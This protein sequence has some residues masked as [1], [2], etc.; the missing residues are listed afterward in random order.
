MEVITAK[1]AHEKTLSIIPNQIKIVVP[2]VFKDIQTEIDKGNFR[3]SY[4]REYVDEWFLMNW[5]LQRH[6]NFLNA[7]AIVMLIIMA[8]I[9]VMILLQFLGKGEHT[10]EQP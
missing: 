3:I 6:K 1:E 5:R 2:F 4:Y 10:N 9:H 7:L 8:E